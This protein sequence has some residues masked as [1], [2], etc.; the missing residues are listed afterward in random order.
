[1]TS[2]STD[3]DDHVP[4]QSSTAGRIEVFDGV[5]GWTCGDVLLTLWQRPARAARVREVSRWV[6]MMLDDGPE[7]FAACQFLLQSAKPPDRGGRAA[8]QEGLRQFGPQARR[9]ITV[10]LGSGLWQRVVR[11]IIRAAVRVFGHAALVKVAANEEKAFELLAQVATDRS[12]DRRQVIAG[13]VRLYGAL[14][15]EPPDALVRQSGAEHERDR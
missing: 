9:L 1:M 4:V 5:V 11:T 2:P 8:A 14:D 7:S 15:L 13:L 12:P 6:G 10:P 3:H